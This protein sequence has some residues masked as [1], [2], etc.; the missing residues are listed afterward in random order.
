MYF[1]TIAFHLLE[2]EA[3]D[4]R[5]KYSQHQ[6]TCPPQQQ[7]D[8]KDGMKD[9]KYFV[10]FRSSKSYK[11]YCGCCYYVMIENIAGNPYL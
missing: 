2:D 3:G 9:A 7:S 1:F 4:R 6:S 5:L 8:C 10:L 11:Q